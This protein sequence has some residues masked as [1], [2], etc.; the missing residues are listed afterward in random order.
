MKLSGTKFVMT[1]E[2][3][4]GTRKVVAAQLEALGA[5][6]LSAVSSAC[7]LLIV[8]DKPGSKLQKA[9]EKGIKIVDEAWVKKILGV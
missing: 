2:L 6:E 4:M 8:G 7:N 3:E 1:G 5:E 9:Q